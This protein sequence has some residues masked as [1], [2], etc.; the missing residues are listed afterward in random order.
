MRGQFKSRTYSRLTIPKRQI[1]DSSELKEF[2]DDNFRFNESGGMFSKRVENT[3]GKG[4]IARYEQFLLFQLCFQKICI[5]YTQKPGLVWERLMSELHCLL[6][7]LHAFSI[8][9]LLSHTV[10]EAQGNLGKRIYFS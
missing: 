4:K 10:S 8:R 3:A 5:A 7:W 9:M 2:A 1:L 6:Y